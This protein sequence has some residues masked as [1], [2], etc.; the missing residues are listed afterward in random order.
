MSLAA[1]FIVDKK[2]KERKCPLTCG[3][4][5]RLW[6]SNTTECSWEFKRNEEQ[7]RATMWMILKNSKLSA[8][9]QTQNPAP[10]V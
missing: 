9:N 8:R 2:R 3:Q 7:I 5:N 4:I 1:F 6:D 10:I